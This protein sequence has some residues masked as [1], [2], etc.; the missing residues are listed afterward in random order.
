MPHPR[1]SNPR[2]QRAQMPHARPEAVRTARS[3]APLR[4]IVLRACAP[5]RG[6]V[7]PFPFSALPSSPVSLRGAPPR[8]ERSFQRSSSLSSGKV[9][10]P[11]T[12]MVNSTMA[13]VVVISIGAAVLV[14]ARL[15]ASANAIAPRSP[16]HGA[17]RTCAQVSR[18][19][20]H[21]HMS[22]QCAH[23]PLKNMTNCMSGVMGLRRRKRLARNARG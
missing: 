8:A 20:P 5:S 15:I 1:H 14:S 2:P 22:R 21:V 16:V 12:T 18:P 13:S 7:D 3:R 17:R 6:A 23:L 10:P 11:K 19:E 4:L 9:P